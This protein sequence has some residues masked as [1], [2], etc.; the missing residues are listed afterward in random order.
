MCTDNAALIVHQSLAKL[1]LMQ[2][3][4]CYA[5]EVVLLTQLVCKTK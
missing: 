2:L 4:M 3:K 5:F 1:T